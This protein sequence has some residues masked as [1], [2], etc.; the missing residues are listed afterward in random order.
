MPKDKT[1]SHQ[2]IVQAALQEFLQKG[3]EQASMKA[4]ADAVGMTPAALYRHFSGKQAMFAALVQPAV[5]AAGQWM[6]RHEQSS[7][8]ALNAPAASCLWEFD[9]GMNDAGLVLEVMYAR[10]EAW[11]L[12][13]FCSAGTP[14]EGFL[15]GIIEQATDRMMDFVSQ[16]RAQ[17]HPAREI[18]RDEMHMLITAYAM[19]MTEPL[20]HGYSREQ[21]RE[22]LH[23][24]IDFFTPGWR[25]ITGL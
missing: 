14:Y 20:Q 25:L 13:L 22:Y 17:G 9:S 11:R 18:A 15:H 23:T 19:A 4:V 7:Y 21:A 16:S 2:K 12:L 8:D 6:N 24:I 5:Q 1:R 10:P 3:Y